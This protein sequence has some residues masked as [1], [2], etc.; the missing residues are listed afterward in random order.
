MAD[1]FPE[2]YRVY[3][4]WRATFDTSPENFMR[5]QQLNE[6]WDLVEAYADESTLG[7]VVNEWW[8]ANVD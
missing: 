2:Q 5:W 8:E 3:N 1:D 4:L 7:S 6:L